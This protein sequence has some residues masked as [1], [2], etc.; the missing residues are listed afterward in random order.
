MNNKLITFGFVCLGISLVLFGGAVLAARLLTPPQNYKEVTETR[1]LSDFT[2]INFET[3]GDV[4]VRKGTKNQITIT[5][6]DVFVSALKTEVSNNT[7]NITGKDFKIQL[8]AFNFSPNTKFVI[9]VKN[10]SDITSKGA[11]NFTIDELN[12]SKDIII[13]MQGVGNL[14]VSKLTAENLVLQ[15]EGTGEIKLNNVLVKTS[16]INSKGVG[17][18]FISGKATSAKYTVEGVGNL[19]AK[20]FVCEDVDINIDGTGNSDVYASKTLKIDSNGVG[21]VTYYGNASVTQN[22]NGVGNISKGLYKD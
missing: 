11:G 9:T 18:T 16:T 4:E 13:D 6:S 2:K 5:S 15:H 19:N 22:K 7:L 12:N 14:E 3:F 8:F 17:Q 10:L 20:D 1:E 21:N